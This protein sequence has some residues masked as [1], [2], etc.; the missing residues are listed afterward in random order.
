MACLV[1]VYIQKLKMT[2]Q[3]Q[4]RGTQHGALLKT[5]SIVTA[6]KFHLVLPRG[7]SDKSEKLQKKVS[8]KLSLTQLQR[9]KVILTTLGASLP[10]L[11][12]FILGY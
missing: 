9:N 11:S 12:L 8:C 3:P 2:M 7:R 6:A 4:Q 1:A 10:P 5:L